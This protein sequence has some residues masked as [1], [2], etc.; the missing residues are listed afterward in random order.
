MRDRLTQL[1]EASFRINE[2]L[3]LE[4][5]LQGV[6]DTAR[7]LTNSTDGVLTTLDKS[8]RPHDFVPSEMSA[9]HHRTLENYTPEGMLMY[10]YLSGLREPLRVSNY[11]D[12]ASSIG[13]SYI[14]PFSISSSLTVPIR[15]AGEAVGNIYLAMQEQG[16]DYTQEDEE[17]LVCSPLRP[18][19]SSPTPGHTGKSGWQGLTWKP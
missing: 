8:E 11:S 3:D 6:V 4:T 13:I 2:S 1:C 5:V 19:W 17:T 9:E 15:H 10:N 12:Y 16:K 7:T 18:R 14:L